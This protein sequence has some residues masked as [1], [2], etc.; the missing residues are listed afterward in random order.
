MLLGIITDIH[1]EVDL[2]REALQVLADRQVERIIC[3]GDVVGHC[4]RLSETC[5]LLAQAQVVGV[6]GNHDYGLSVGPGRRDRGE[7]PRAAGCGVH[8]NTRTTHGDRRLLVSTRR[9][10]ARPVQT[11][12][13]V[14]FRRVPQR[15]DQ[16]ARIFAVPTARIA[17]AGHF[18]R[19]LWAR[20]SGLTAWKGKRPSGWTPRTSTLSSSVPSVL[21]SSPPMTPAAAGSPQPLVSAR[22]W[23][24]ITSDDSGRTDAPPRGGRRR[25]R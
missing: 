7:L 20:P 14:V 16:L 17:F 4:L 24:R 25:G 9:T 3:V 2:L 10:L 12:R 1:E 11:G 18:H 22:E 21:V 19:W 13:S 5:Q 6:Y 8:A 15:P 23:R